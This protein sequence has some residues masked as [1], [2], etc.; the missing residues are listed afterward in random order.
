MNTKSS[1]TLLGILIF[2]VLSMGLAFGQQTKVSNTTTNTIKII[3]LQPTT[4]EPRASGIVKVGV[5][6]DANSKVIE[7]GFIAAGVNLISGGTY[8]LVVDNIITD[9]TVSSATI[10]SFLEFA[11]SSSNKSLK[12]MPKAMKPV[13]NIKHVEIRNI[14][15]RVVLT[16][17]FQ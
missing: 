13:G 4:V 3:Q 14:Q 6:V 2:L 7:Q 1:F 9:T 15:G 5:I 11:Y 12:A 16:G 17:D 8:I 10:N